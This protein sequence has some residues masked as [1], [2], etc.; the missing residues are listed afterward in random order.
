MPRD[1]SFLFLQSGAVRLEILREKS[2]GEDGRVTD[3]FHLDSPIVLLF[4]RSL[5]IHLEGQ[6]QGH[7]LLCSRDAADNLLRTTFGGRLAGIIQTVRD[8]RSLVYRPSG[9]DMEF[10]GGILSLIGEEYAYREKEWEQV[11]ELHLLELLTRLKRMTPLSDLKRESLNVPESVWTIDDVIRYVEEN[12]DGSFSLDDLASRCSLNTSYF[13]RSFKE[14]RGIPLFEFINRI[15]IDRACRLLRDSDRTV[16]DIALT[17]GYNNVSFFNRYFRRLMG[18]SA[19]AYR[20][21][22]K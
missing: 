14:H 12:F 5:G 8:G 2:L 11:V 17:V 18:E 13:S 7:L 1:L 6:G 16:L 4:S 21:R 20:R 22:M 15:R 9:L 19:G 3:P 10:L